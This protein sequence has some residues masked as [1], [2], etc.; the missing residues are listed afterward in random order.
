MYKVVI[1][2]KVAKRFNTVPESYLRGL[3]ALLEA[4]AVNPVPWKD[5]DLKKMEGVDNT[6]RVRIG[7]YR[8]VYFVEKE[9]QTIHIL[10]FD[11]REKVYKK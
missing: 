4:I 7:D 9:K 5:F 1:H 11:R 3:S 8:V 6:Y 2:R 10:K